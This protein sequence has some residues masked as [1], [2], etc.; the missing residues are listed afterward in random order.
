MTKRNNQN[1]RN[2]SKEKIN[3]PICNYDKY[4][5][6]SYTENGWGVVEQYGYCDRC[7][8]M[9]DQC[10]SRPI[11]GFC[12]PRKRGGKGYLGVYY[13][14]NSR[15]RKRIKRRYNIKYGSED[16]KLRYI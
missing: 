2:R 13:P 16:W 4:E 6:K 15:K 14:K 1:V 10:Y 12:P 7:G 8:Y 5:Y 9:I 11:D 3:C